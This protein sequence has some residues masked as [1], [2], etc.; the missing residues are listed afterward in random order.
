MGPRLFRRG[1]TAAKYS[2][3]STQPLQWGHAF[4][5]VDT[6]ESG[7][8][9]GYMTMLQWG[10]AFSGVDTVPLNFERDLRAMPESTWLMVA[11]KIRNLRLDSFYHT[12]AIFHLASVHAWLL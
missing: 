10:H 5:G 4:S 8:R 12:P 11:Q 2:V 7:I 6:A 9:A 3:C 1:Y